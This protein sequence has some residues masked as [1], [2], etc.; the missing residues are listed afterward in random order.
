M[1]NTLLTNLKRTV[2]P[3]A[4]LL[5]LGAPAWSGTFDDA[6]VIDVTG[7]GLIFSDPAEGVEPPGLKAVTGEVNADF[8]NT[9]N[10]QGI[11]NCLM[12]NTPDFTCTAPPGSGKR[13]K[14]QLTGPTPMDIMLSTQSSGD[15]TEYFTYGKTSNLTGAR[16][17]AFKVQLGTGSGDSFTPFDTADP[18]TAALFDPDY[19]SKFNLPDGLFGDGGQEG[20]GIGFFDGTSAEMT[21]A[22]TANTLDATNL[23]NSVLATYFGESLIDNS[24][25]PTA[26]FWDATG[27]DVVSDEPVLIAWHNLSADQWQYG[28]LGV[29]GTDLDIKL[30]AMADSLGVTVADLGYTGGG[31]VPADIVAAMQANG[32]Y[33]QDVVEDLRN[34]NL[35]YIIDLGD[36]AGSNVTM[37]IAPIFAPIVEQ[38][39]TPYQFATAGRLDAAANIPYL[40][41]GNAATYQTAISDIMAITDP[42]ARNDMLETTGYSFLPAFGAVGFE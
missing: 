37:R 17:L 20:T 35:N 29:S 18:K 2:A 34:L 15:I 13:V 25:L 7:D 19:N 11:T 1:S 32:L 36:V 28:N 24:M 33:T 16:I 38:T 26:F 4:L 30:Q 10:P 31:A 23:S 9:N 40:D 41:I 6:P 21:I 5:C 8:G 39:A 12:A 14:T 22:N 42:V 27:T 3:A